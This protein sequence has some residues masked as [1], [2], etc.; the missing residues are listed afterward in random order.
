M[1]LLKKRPTRT[2][3]THLSVHQVGLKYGFRSGL[4]EAIAEDLTSCGVGFSYEELVI[5]Y[6][7]PAKQSRYTPDFVLENGIIVES[8][9]R[10]LTEDRQKMILIK[11]Q[12]PQLDIRFVFSNS[13]TKI[14]KRSKTTYGNWADKYGFPYADRLIPNDWK[15]EPADKARMLALQQMSNSEASGRVLVPQD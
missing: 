3:K 2:S 11:Q 6:V 1:A 12:Y 5:R 9:G 4:E 10:Y 8:K 15:N 7:K 14:S 13:K